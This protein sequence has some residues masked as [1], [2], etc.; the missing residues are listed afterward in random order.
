MTCLVKKLAWF[1]IVT[2]SQV[3]IHAFSLGKRAAQIKSYTERTLGKVIGEWM[4][5]VE[6]GKKEKN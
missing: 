5:I 4:G 1:S 2:S 6:G 3:Q